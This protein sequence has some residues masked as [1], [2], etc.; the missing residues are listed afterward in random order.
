MSRR[1]ESGALS[2]RRFETVRAERAQR[3]ARLTLFGSRSSFVYGES[4][5]GSAGRD[6][7]SKSGGMLKGTAFLP[8]R[9]ELC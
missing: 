5:N 1:D 6:F 7:H 9:D 4:E 3:V 8:A 2:E